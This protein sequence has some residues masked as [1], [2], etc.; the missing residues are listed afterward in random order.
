MK[1]HFYKYQGTGNDFIL[2]D[3]R[4]LL[5]PKE[6]TK[7]IHS[8]CDRRFGIG[9][10]GLML[11]EN[12][13]A[14]DFK[15]VYYNADGNE[16][17]MCGNGGR[18]IASFAGLLNIVQENG[19]FIAIDG[20]HDFEIADAVV[21][22][23]M[24]NVS[25]IRQ[26]INNYIL[27]TG[28]PHY[29]SFRNAIDTLEI[30]EEARKIRYNDEFAKEGINVNFVEEKDDKIYMR[31]YERGVE[32]ETL[33]CGTGTVAVALSIAEK[34]QLSQGKI[35]IQTPG[36]ILF[37]SFEKQGTIFTNIWLEGAAQKVF[38]GDIEI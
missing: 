34:H 26:E 36:G 6:N 2:I 35:E 16:S 11:L 4:S 31:T 15:M 9:A 14:Y 33:S 7:L 32:G 23:K 1:I 25:T 18:C 17:T 20:E 8:L 21:K 28:S 10:D 27:F 12:V 30:V 13:T 37:V 24:I 29:V 22:L 19:K 5:F 38:E 3:N